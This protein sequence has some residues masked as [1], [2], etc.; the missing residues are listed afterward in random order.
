MAFQESSDPFIEKLQNLIDDLKQNADYQEFDEVLKIIDEKFPFVNILDFVEKFIEGEYSNSLILK[1]HLNGYN[2]YTKLLSILKINK[3]RP[4]NKSPTSKALNLSDE[5][6]CDRY[7]FLQKA[8]SKFETSII[9]RVTFNVLRAVVIFQLFSNL[10]S[11]SNRNKILEF[12]PQ[13][14]KGFEHLIH[15][16]HVPLS[17]L[18]TITIES[19]IDSIILGLQNSYSLEHDKHG[20]FRL[21]NHYLNLSDYILNILQNRP[22]G[23]L[24]QNLISILKEKLPIL[25]QIPSTLIE[26]TIHDLTSNH[27]VIKKEGYWKFKP[28]FDK[29][30]TLD[31]YRDVGPENLYTTYEMNKRFFGRSISPDEFINELGQLQ[32]GDFADDDD[33]VTRIASMILPNTNSLN[34]PPP[35]LSEFDFSVDLS[36]YRFT[37]EQNQIIKELDFQIRSPII[38]VKVMID[39]RI[40]SELIIR[41]ID[42]IK[43]HNKL[44]S[45]NQI[46]QGF[47]ISFLPFGEET[48]Q[49]LKQDK[50]IQI[51]SMTALRKWCKI[52]PIIACRKSAVTI[53]RQGDHKGKIA[54]INS[55]NYESG[56]T[57]IILFPEM[58]STTHYIGSLEEINLDIRADKFTDYSNIYFH[59]LSKLIQISDTNLFNKII[60]T[61]LSKLKTLDRDTSLNFTVDLSECRFV[62]G[63]IARIFFNNQ[64]DLNSLHYSTEDLFSC[65]CTQWNENSR[66]QGLCEHLIFTINE[67]IRYILSIRSGVHEHSVERHLLLIEKRME[68]YLKRLRYSN[69]DNQIAKCPACGQTANTIDSVEDIFGYRQM[70][71]ENKFSLRRQS[72]CKKC[73]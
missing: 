59:F 70:D 27:K 2:D 17:T 10:D 46:E 37:R 47:V 8:F 71:K 31:N 63:N 15:A 39:R 9:D 36:K 60:L 6:L 23:I 52:T 16:S 54:K 64:L 43:L 67:S 68:L 22:N 40:S 18:A 25:S 7:N 35:N 1:F 34:W 42:Q 61:D 29:Y 58:K 13:S 51:I 11:F 48:T 66:S 62:D 69:E 24:Y 19:F 65:S 44:E 72:R 56:L 57:E 41:L 20:N 50:T 12:L 3:K 5:Y 26:I 38:H 28:F 4:A 32:K 21:A 30:F 49:I 53:V 33:Q 14:I 45:K 73:R 55:I